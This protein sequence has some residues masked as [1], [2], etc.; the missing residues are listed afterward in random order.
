MLDARFEEI[1]RS[2]GELPSA[3]A[4][5]GDQDLRGDLGM[6]SLKL[7]DLIVH[8]EAEYDVEFGD[9]AMNGITTVEQLWLEVDRAS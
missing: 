5:A 3:L 1:L 9:D 7:M 6:D 2:V 4:L 8:L